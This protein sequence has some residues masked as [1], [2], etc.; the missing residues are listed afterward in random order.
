MSQHVPPIPSIRLSPLRR[1]RSWLVGL[2]LAVAIAATGTALLVADNSGTSTS[3]QA[4]STSL[5][6]P[7]ETLRGSAVAAASGASSSLSTSGS[8]NETARGQAV[9]STSGPFSTPIDGPNEAARGSA[10]T[11]AASSP[12]P[13]GGVDETARGQAV[14]SASR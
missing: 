5:S 11:S 12:S 10:V 7:N 3:N 6:G 8:V 13:V 2:V 14:A 4:V 9:A 1:G